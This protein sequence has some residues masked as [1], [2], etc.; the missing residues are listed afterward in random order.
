M[1][2]DEEER[3][4]VQE[5][6]TITRDEVVVGRQGAT[7]AA[8]TRDAFPG[9]FSRG[10]LHKHLASQLGKHLL[11]VV[12]ARDSGPRSLASAGV[13]RRQ[14]KYLVSSPVNQ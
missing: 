13:V 11:V 4:G 7:F 6:S 9:T 8:K 5:A 3:A 10:V 12:L 2:A 1:P 14:G